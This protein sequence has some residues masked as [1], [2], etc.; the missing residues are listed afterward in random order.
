D[1]TIMSYLPTYFLDYREKLSNIPGQRWSDR[2]TSQDGNWSG[3]VFDFYLK[4]IKRVNE[5]VKIPFVLEGDELTRQMDTRVHKAL[6]EAVLNTLIHADY[7]ASSNI[8]IEKERN[9]YRFSNP[10]L[11][12]IPFQQAIEGGMSDARNRQL[13]K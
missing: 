11:M 8:V 2:I 13:F 9:L 4:V 10:G 3:N 12:R 1:M 6:R 5:D 7:F